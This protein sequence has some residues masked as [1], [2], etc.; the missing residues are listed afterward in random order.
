MT[1][2]DRQVI[3][4]CSVPTTAAGRPELT[5]W[6]DAGSPQAEYSADQVEYSADQA[7]VPAA[8]PKAQAVCPH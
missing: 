3:R 2:T 7:I 5:Q 1:H 8:K 4:R 6:A